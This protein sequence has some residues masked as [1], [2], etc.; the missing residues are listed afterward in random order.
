MR[1]F[2]GTCVGISTG[3]IA[4]SGRSAVTEEMYELM[5]S[6]RKPTDVRIAMEWSVLAAAVGTA[7][8]R[9]G[10]RRRSCDDGSEVNARS[11]EG[12]EGPDPVVEV[13]AE[14]TGLSGTPRSMT[15]HTL[16]DQR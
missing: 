11:R 16:R 13:E 2:P 14:Y 3:E 15:I 1:F 10:A 4:A 9:R 7:G 8:V 5:G 12:S 6:V